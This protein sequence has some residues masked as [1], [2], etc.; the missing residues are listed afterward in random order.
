[1]D[2]ID[3]LPCS[4]SAVEN[5][6]KAV[7]RDPLILRQPGSRIKNIPHKPLI[8]LLQIEERRDVFTRDDQDMDRRLGV[9]VPKGHNGLVLVDDIPF[10]I[11]FDDAAEKTTVHFISSL[12]PSSSSLP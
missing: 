4:R 3:A 9:D 2:V 10:D 12:E 8:P 5:H 11:A 7:L 6:A 1:M